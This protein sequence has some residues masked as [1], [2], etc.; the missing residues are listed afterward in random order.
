MKKT[1]NVIPGNKRVS[2]LLALGKLF[3]TVGL[4]GSVRRRHVFQHRDD[5]ADQT[6]HLGE[7]IIAI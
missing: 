6:F 3:V 4:V 5:L 7:R 2:F 1:M